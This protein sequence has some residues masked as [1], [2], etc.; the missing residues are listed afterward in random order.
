V[1]TEPETTDQV[2]V[3]S[4]GVGRLEPRFKGQVCVVTGG[5]RGIGKAIGRAIA[6]EGGATALVARTR[7]ECVRATDEIEGAGGE[8][9]AV[10]GD[11]TDPTTCSAVIGLVTKWRG[12]PTVLINAAGVSPV[13]ERA[14]THDV[15]AWRTVMDTNL[16]GAYLMTRAAA[17]ALIEN[18]GSIVNVASA[19]GLTGSPRLSAYGASKAGLIQLTRTLAREWGQHGVRVNAVCPGYARTG[20]T[21]KFLS[22]THLRDRV[23][24]STALG[25]LAEIDEIVGP[26]L[27]LASREA[28]YVTGAVLT[29]DGGMTA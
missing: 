15:T 27:F 23:V 25:R 22:V 5:G 7:K 28:S 20:M 24:A 29:V 13:R 8:A 9:L 16:L 10:E 14:E 2:A 19:L 12:P 11:V 18:R 4:A 17:P 1:R 3:A 21:E 26:T 6:L